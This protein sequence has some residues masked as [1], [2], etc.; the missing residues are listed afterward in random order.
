[1]VARVVPDKVVAIDVVSLSLV[2]VYVV[3]LGKVFSVVEVV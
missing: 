1:V 2:E 3:V